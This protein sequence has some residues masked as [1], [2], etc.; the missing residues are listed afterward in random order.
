[1]KPVYRKVCGFCFL[2]PNDIKLKAVDKAGNEQ[3]GEQYNGFV[4]IVHGSVLKS[5]ST[6]VTVIAIFFSKHV[7][8]HA[9]V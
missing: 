9:L 7:S 3:Q 4:D 8:T 6:F 1:V 2:Y 5:V